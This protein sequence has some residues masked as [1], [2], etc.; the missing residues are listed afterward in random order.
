MQTGFIKNAAAPAP[1]DV[2]TTEVMEITDATASLALPQEF[3][4]LQERLRDPR[5]PK[6]EWT[7]KAAAAAFL[8]QGAAG[9]DFCL[10]IALGCDR[11]PDSRDGGC[12]DRKGRRKREQ[13][14]TTRRD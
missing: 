11:M 9:L 1:A 14:G 5:P 12:R 13:K 4:V 7:A 6:P 3:T 10:P 8:E 2:T